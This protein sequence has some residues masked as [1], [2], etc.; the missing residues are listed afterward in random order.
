MTTTFDPTQIATIANAVLVIVATI[1]VPVLAIIAR[2]GKKALADVKDIVDNAVQAS[3]DGKLTPQEVENII[4]DI[5]DLVS[6]SQDIIK[7]VQ[8]PTVVNNTTN[9]AAPAPSGTA[10][11]ATA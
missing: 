2:K 3:N 11:T 9:V 8:T 4:N 6:T 7:V 1:G 5:K 10:S